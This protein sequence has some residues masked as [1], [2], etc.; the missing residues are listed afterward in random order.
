MS[1][2]TVPRNVIEGRS[3]P[4]PAGVYLGRL[5]EAKEAW[6][7]D[8]KSL[9]VS[10]QIRDITALDGPNVGARP[11]SQRLAIV[12]KGYN[13]V[14][15]KDFTDDNIPF[16]IRTS[17][18]LLTQIAIAFGAATVTPEGARVDLDRFLQDLVAGAYKD[19]VV[20]FSVEQ[21]SFDSKTQKTPDGKPL[22]QTVSNLTY[23]TSPEAADVA[24]AEAVALATA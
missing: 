12:A 24:A 6:S 11:Y 8:Q 4:F 19:R 13:V 16:P 7:E 17:A 20:Q 18:G 2:V 15:L 1:D 5:N 14:D 23:V 22:R 9:N 21:R 10:V 3:A